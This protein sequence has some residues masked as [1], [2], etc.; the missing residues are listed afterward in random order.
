MK[1][2]I[3]TLSFVVSGYSLF[4]QDIKVQRVPVGTK[5]SPETSEVRLTLSARIQ[6]YNSYAKLNNDIYDKTIGSPKSAIILEE[7]NKFYINNLENKA[8]TVYNLEN[9][10]MLKNIKHKFTNENSFLFKDT[11][12]FDYKFNTRSSQFNIFEGKPVEGCFSHNKKFLWV[13]YYRRTYDR[14]AVDPSALAIIDTDKDEIIRVM[15]TGPLPKMIACSPDNRYIAVTHWGDNTIGIID[16]SSNDVNNFKY[17]KLFQVGKRINLKFDN[18]TKIDR[19]KDCGYCLR[20]TVFSPDS[21][22]L[23]VA[24]MGGGGIAVFDMTNMKY[25]RSVFGMQTNI[26]HLTVL[27]DLLY[28]STNITGYVQ[29]ANIYDL[30]D[31]AINSESSYTNWRS[32]YV[33]KGVRTIAVSADGKYIFAAVN[34]ESRVA[35]IKAADM[36]IISTIDVDSFPVGM[37]IATESSKLIV[38]SQGRISCGGGQSVMIFDIEN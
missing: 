26:R 20:G 29:I 11:S 25:I 4:S 16:I 10:T 15:P 14:N 37:D 36:S 23:L 12:L 24:R 30:I 19:D 34:N 9:L 22:Y 21:K 32:R 18:A 27:G 31:S 5:S 17:T 13:T 35:V 28:I 33:G 2:L 38:T 7:K 6:G 3:F 1:Y 8:T